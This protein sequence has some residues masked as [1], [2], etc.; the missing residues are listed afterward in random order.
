[1]KVKIF[2]TKFLTVHVH[3]LAFTC[4]LTKNQVSWHYQHSA[5]LW[6]PIHAHMNYWFLL[7]L[8]IRVGGWGWVR[9]E[10]LW[11]VRKSSHF[12]VHPYGKSPGRNW[13]FLEG[14]TGIPLRFVIPSR[15]ISPGRNSCHF[16][17]SGRNSF[18]E[19]HSL[20]E[21]Q[22]RRGGGRCRPQTSARG[23]PPPPP[24][25]EGI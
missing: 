7:V 20:Q 5:A 4:I 3:V 22:L 12:S 1:M 13:T 21:F 23:R 19:F 15:K 18:Q 11:H 9:E 25:N 24:A 17:P 6:V 14:L 16:C 10:I 8:E 2:Y